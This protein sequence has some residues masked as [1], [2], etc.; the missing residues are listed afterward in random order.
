[1]HV[2]IIPAR[3]ELK[4]TRT[5]GRMYG[6]PVNYQKRKETRVDAL[7]TACDIDRLSFYCAK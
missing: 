2:P 4:Y 6:V 3:L 5:I 7:C 1:M